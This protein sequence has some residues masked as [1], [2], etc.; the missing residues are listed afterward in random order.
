MVW[1]LEDYYDHQHRA[2]LM[3]EKH[4]RLRPLKIR[5]H[6]ASSND[7]PYDE[8]Y[9]EY[10]KRLGLL[11]FITLVSRSTP[12]LN[13]AAITALVDRW[14]PETHTFHLRTGEIT[15]TLQD[16]SMIFGLPIAGEPLCMSTDSDGWR[17]A[18][19]LLIGMAP[20]ELEDKRKDRVPAG[21][22]YAWIVENFRECP[23]PAE[24]EVI[25]THARVYV[26][27][28]FSRT[29]FA[30][31]GGRTAQWMWLK[32]LANWD[33]NISWGSAALAY[34][35]RQL[36]DACRRAGES[37]GIGGA[38]VLLSI[39]SWERLPVGRPKE[40]GHHPWPSY[41][42]NPLRQPT[43]AYKWDVVSEMTSDVDAMYL[44]YT[45]QFDAITPEQKEAEEDQELG[46]PS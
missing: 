15:P 14:R 40:V 2:Y 6:G 41:N 7:M 19:H 1:L 9:T 5:S 37:A 3:A 39:W 44:K 8:R 32:A 11:P 21:A 12:N 23:N 20:E 25:E 36:D 33:S 46:S 27:Y 17:N 24:V 45:K 31:S 26:W 38:M 30:N 13:A 29:L 28:V 34:L 16:V 42:R 18:M 22:T 35:Y 10:I 43:W 4:M